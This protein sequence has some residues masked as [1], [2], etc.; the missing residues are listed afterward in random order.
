MVSDT[1]ANS[2]VAEEVWALV[3]KYFLDR[4]FGG[5]DWPATREQI[6]KMSPLTDADALDESTKIVKKLGDRYS[7]VLTPTQ[8]VKLALSIR[9]PIVT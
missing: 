9:S 4:T 3:D 7:R 5:Q 6:R 2:P 1:A 8:A